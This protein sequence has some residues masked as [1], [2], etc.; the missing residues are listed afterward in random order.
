LKLVEGIQIS[1]SME[2]LSS[3]LWGLFLIVCWWMG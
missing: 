2:Q 3:F 1:T